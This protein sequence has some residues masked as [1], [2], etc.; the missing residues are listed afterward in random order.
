MI[1]AN[2]QRRATFL[3]LP[4]EILFLVCEFVDLA[5]LRRLIRSCRR[6]TAV[7]LPVYLARHGIRHPETSLFLCPVTLHILRLLALARPVPSTQSLHCRFD[8]ASLPEDIRAL[9]L[10]VSS[11]PV[12]KELTL[13]FRA[14]HS[15]AVST[16]GSGRCG[17]ADA[18]RDTLDNVLA[19]GCES[20][21][22]LDGVLFSA[23]Y[24]RS[25]SGRSRDGLWSSLG[26][27]FVRYLGERGWSSNAPTQK[28]KTFNIHSTMMLL[29]PFIE[30]T[31]RILR[32]NAHLSDLLLGSSQFPSEDWDKILPYVTLP[33]L[34]KFSIDIARH[35][36]DPP[37]KQHSAVRAVFAFVSR[38]STIT[39]FR[40]LDPCDPTG[41]ERPRSMLPLL[42]SLDAGPTYITYLLDTPDAFPHLERISISLPPIFDD[43]VSLHNALSAIGQ[44]STDIAL[45]IQL[46]TLRPNLLFWLSFG[47]GEAPAERVE[48][49]LHC[50]KKLELHVRTIARSFVS[51]TQHA[52]PA[53]LSL[54]PEL[55]YLEI[56]EYSLPFLSMDA[57][58]SFVQL[59]SDSCPKLNAVKLHSEEHDVHT[60]LAMPSEQ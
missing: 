9:H 21:T 39:E 4:N 45:C 1:I 60:W 29:P 52:L 7:A 31:M 12:V 30:Q 53:W 13:D 57:K 32:S 51:S 15:A 22:I 35:D 50:V 38:H 16:P 54:F 49:S 37:A 2:P 11:S 46:P 36:L 23:K 47:L 8:G 28:L 25:S 27:Q 19:S 58:R 20:L 26:C 42:A 40:C 56:D 43:F 17:V 5:G 44:R 3:D 34:R 48:R 59:L 24:A 41:V 18:I 6:L 55:R 10:F 33:C 14:V